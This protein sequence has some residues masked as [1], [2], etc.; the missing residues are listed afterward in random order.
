MWTIALIAVVG[1]LAVGLNVTLL[2]EKLKGNLDVISS[3]AKEPNHI[4]R[5]T[6]ASC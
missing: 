6:N 4:H 1:A 5:V 2:I 3:E